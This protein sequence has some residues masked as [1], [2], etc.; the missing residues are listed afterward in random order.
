MAYI[1]GAYYQGAYIRGYISRGLIT[2]DIY[3]G[4]YIS[5]RYPGAYIRGTFYRWLTAEVYMPAYIRGG[6]YLGGLKSTL[7][8]LKDSTCFTC[9]ERIFCRCA[10]KRKYHLSSRRIN[11]TFIKYAWHYS[12][13]LL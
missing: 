13:I 6:F 7:I 1:L 8:I 11:I 5:G 2:G 3:P 9:V 12:L 10:I 4:A